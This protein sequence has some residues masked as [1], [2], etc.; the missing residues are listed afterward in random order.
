MNMLYIQLIVVIEIV[1]LCLAHVMGTVIS[2]KSWWSYNYPFAVVK[3]A[4]GDSVTW[5]RSHLLIQTWPKPACHGLLY[6]KFYW[7]AVIP[8]HL[9]Y[10]WLCLCYWSKVES[11]SPSDTVWSLEPE[12]CT[13]W[14]HQNMLADSYPG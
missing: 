6:I 5:P 13:M 7:N 9:C 4:E 3:D 12:I 1:N 8:A 10:L 2:V 14:S 11:S